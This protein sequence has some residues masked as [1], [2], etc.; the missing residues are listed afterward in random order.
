MNVVRYFFGVIFGAF[1]I[2]YAFEAVSKPESMSWLSTFG[3]I[4]TFLIYAVSATIFLVIARLL[5][6]RSTGPRSRAERE[7]WNK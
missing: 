1:G 5:W 7:G 2:V 4:E 6:P 3:K